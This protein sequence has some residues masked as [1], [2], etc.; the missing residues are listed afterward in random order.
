[1]VLKP[2]EHSV[3]ICTAHAC[4]HQAAEVWLLVLSF[5][6][7][8]FSK[9]CFL[10]WCNVGAIWTQF[11][12][13]IQHLPDVRSTF[14]ERMLV[15]CWNRLN[16]PLARIWNR[17]R[18]FLSIVF[19]QLD[20]RVARFWHPPWASAFYD[21]SFVKLFQLFWW[22]WIV[23]FKMRATT[24]WSQLMRPMN[25]SEPCTPGKMWPDVRN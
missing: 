12:F 11:Y 2:F 10:G 3:N 17:D 18:P 21:Q 23:L 15:K 6:Q 1:M 24:E 22:R 20:K 8:N 7:S 5:S 19:Y 14:V 13:C 4:S 16:G 25:G 9:C